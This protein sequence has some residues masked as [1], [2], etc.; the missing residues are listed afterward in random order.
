MPLVQ[1]RS[2]DLLT[3]SLA[4]L[5]LCYGC[6][7]LFLSVWYVAVNYFPYL[8]GEDNKTPT[9]GII[10]SM[11]IFIP[12]YIQYSTKVSDNMHNLSSIG[13]FVLMLILCLNLSCLLSL[14]LGRAEVIIKAEFIVES[15]QLKLVLGVT[16]HE[17]NHLLIVVDGG[18]IGHLQTFIYLSTTKF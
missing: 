1:D 4:M 9:A 12:L 18:H 15:P 6:P 11:Y 7:P 13:L 5:P 2:L 10:L 16:V 3:S 8:R 17:L 14:C